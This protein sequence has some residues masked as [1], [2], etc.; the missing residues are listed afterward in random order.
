MPDQMGYLMD[1]RIA[2]Q[3]RTVGTA[4]TVRD[5]VVYILHL[6]PSASGPAGPAKERIQAEL[7]Q[8]VDVLRNNSSATLILTSG[9]LPELGTVCPKAEARAR[10]R[11]LTLFQL[12][13]QTEI[14]MAEMMAILNGMGDNM[15]RLVLANKHCS[16][17]RG[18]V[19]LE[20]RYQAYANG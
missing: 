4:Q 15:G 17:T 3:Q 20:T 11:D 8:L 19:A 7:R 5:A 10:S 14:E 12:T 18:T 1:G 2:V 13:N 16:S 6:S 9:L